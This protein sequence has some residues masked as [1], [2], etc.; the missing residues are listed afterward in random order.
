MKTTKITV[1]FP[2]LM[3]AMLCAFFAALGAQTTSPPEARTQF[4]QLHT[5]WDGV[6]TDKQAQ[7]GQALYQ[8]LCSSCHGDKLVA[9]PDEDTPSLTGSDFEVDWNGRTLAEMFKQIQRKMPQDDPGTLT[10][11]QTA[12]LVAFLLSFNKFPAGKT[13][14][15]ADA[16]SL[17]SIRYAVQKPE[18][19][20]GPSQPK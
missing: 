3:I 8:K 2:L 14:L 18:L 15:P 11:K 9:K 10:P 16:E 12:D 13:E 4:P 5:V 1:A 19:P 17:A 6:Y 20:Q 7:R